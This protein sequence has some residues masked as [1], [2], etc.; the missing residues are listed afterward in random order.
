LPLVLVLPV[1]K[2]KL[3]DLHRRGQLR[4]SADL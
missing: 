2:G 1:L 4:Q 3:R